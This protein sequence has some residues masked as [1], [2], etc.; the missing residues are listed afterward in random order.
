MS[1]R[2]MEQQETLEQVEQVAKE[3]TEDLIRKELKLDWIES[4]WFE[5]WLKLARGEREPSA[6]A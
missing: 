5:V 4:D 3:P 6:V 2:L 1:T